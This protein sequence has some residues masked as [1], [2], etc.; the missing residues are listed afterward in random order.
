M[1]ENKIKYKNEYNKQPFLTVVIP[2]LNESKNICQAIDIVNNLIVNVDAEILV[3]DY[4]S[5]D[6]TYVIAKNI[7]K[8][9]NTI[10]SG[11]LQGI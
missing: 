4:K 3:I 2:C 9:R 7:S 1:T 5:D 10:T 8:F 6:E 11:L